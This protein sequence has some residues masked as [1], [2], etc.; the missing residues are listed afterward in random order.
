MVWLHLYIIPNMTNYSDGE[1]I[2][3]CQ[4][5]REGITM[6]KSM[7]MEKFCISSVVVTSLNA[8][9][10]TSQK[11][12]TKSTCKKQWNLKKRSGV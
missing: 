4:G 8:C 6:K 10:K 11:T 9:D 5:W 12:H 1:Q 3:G 2:S 7:V